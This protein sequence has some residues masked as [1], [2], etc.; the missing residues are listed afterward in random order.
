[1]GTQNYLN[2]VVELMVAAKVSPH[3]FLDKTQE[4]EN[5]LGRIRTVKWGDRT[6]DLDILFWNN[7]ILKE[8]NLIIPHPLLQNRLFVLEPMVELNPQLVHPV[9]K[10]SITEL[11]DNLLN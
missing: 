5:Q 9:L 1:P 2:Q 3:D 7:L 6:I 4:I 11:F 10:L 8:D